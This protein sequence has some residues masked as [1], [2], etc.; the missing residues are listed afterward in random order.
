MQVAHDAVY[1]PVFQG[2]P[3]STENLLQLYTV[4]P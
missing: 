1:R 2:K 4:I 3:S